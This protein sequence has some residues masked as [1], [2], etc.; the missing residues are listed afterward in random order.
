M[1]GIGRNTTGAM[2]T[3]KTVH[4]KLVG[5]LVA[6]VLAS[7]VSVHAVITAVDLGTNAPPAMLGGY[8]MTPF[9]S[10]PTAVGTLV[11]SVTSPLGGVVSFS[12]PLKHL[13]VG[14]G[15]STWSHGYAGDVYWAMFDESLDQQLPF[16]QYVTLTLPADTAAFYFYA[17]PN[18]S[19]NARWVMR[20]TAENGPFTWEFVA[21]LPMWSL[22]SEVYGA[23]GW[24]FY[25]D[26]P[27]SLTTLTIFCFTDFAIGEFGIATRGSQIPSVPEGWSGL[28]S[29]W[30][31]GLALASMG[32]LRLRR[33]RS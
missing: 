27:G 9:G 33:C 14:S 5:A 28:S 16:Q 23:N 4:K 12:R 17:Q 19:I 11:T 2:R 21:N 15:W 8:T 32:G 1:W 25:L 20:V 18:V 3:M 26:G 22:V 30:T 29:L 13:V 31:L 7:A 6:T 24:G 10:D